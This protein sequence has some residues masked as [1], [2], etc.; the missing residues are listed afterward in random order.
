V[1]RNSPEFGQIAIE[2]KLNLL[3]QEQKKDGRKGVSREYWL[4]ALGVVTPYFIS[5]VAGLLGY[6]L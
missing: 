5:W 1:F 3:V 6:Q 2:Q 4:Y